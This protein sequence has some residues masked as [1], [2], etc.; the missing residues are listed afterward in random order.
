MAH[1]RKP[2]GHEVLTGKVEA[3]PHAGAGRAAVVV[4]PVCLSFG[5]GWVEP[6]ESRRACL[7]EFGDNCP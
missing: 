5:H 1:N 2:A 7:I 3:P 6:D 4:R